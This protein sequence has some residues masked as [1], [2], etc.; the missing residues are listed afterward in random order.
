MALKCGE[1]VREN[2]SSIY[3]EAETRAA[4]VDA[5]EQE[6]REL[7]G[8]SVWRSLENAAWSS[9]AVREDAMLPLRI[10]YNDLSNWR[11]ERLKFVVDGIAVLSV[12]VILSEMKPLPEKIR[13]QCR[14]VTTQ[15]QAVKAADEVESVLLSLG[16]NDPATSREIFWATRAAASQMSWAVVEASWER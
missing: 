8:P 3:S 11:P 1:P 15:P 6:S 5:M 7:L 14:N 13:N 4:A 9:D 10:A 16:P 12:N 2:L